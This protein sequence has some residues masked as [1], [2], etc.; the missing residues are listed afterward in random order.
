MT[1][2]Q[3]IVDDI[4]SF[5][6]A[7]DQSHTDS[8]RRISTEYEAACQEANQRLRRCEEYLQKGLRSE[9]IHLAE[10][11]PVL[12]DVVAALDF[13]ERQQWEEVALTYGLP[14]PPR[15]RTETASA[16]NQAYADEQPLEQL[17]RRHRRLAL[18]RAPLEERL[19]LMRQISAIDATNPVWADDIAVF[20]RSRLKKMRRDVEQAVKHHDWDGLFGIHD[21]LHKYEWSVAPDPDLVTFVRK[22][23]EHR[24]HI[25]LRRSLQQ[26]ASQLKSAFA[27]A[28][29][30]Q[31][32]MALK[33]WDQLNSEARLDR[34]DPIFRRA[35]GALQWLEQLNRKQETEF[36]YQAAL[37]R[38]E[39]ALAA[40]APQEELAD[41]FYNVRKYK[42][43]LPLDLEQRYS[44]KLQS[45]R[46]AA[47]RKERHVIV[48]T[49]LFGI[50]ALVSLLVFALARHI[51]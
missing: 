30:A 33:E 17:L 25:R 18:E 46:N 26:I 39:D 20:E 41:A 1:D 38:L 3:R 42:R 23:V 11:D 12:L 4:R 40:G 49:V 15:L 31:A 19:L 32:R 35:A 13:P 2:Y 50:V 45:I 48:G 43:N 27:T 28:D 9:A 8:L 24:K 21:E 44:E 5:L 34:Q 29:E 47:S 6:Q 36:A 7:S 14:P 37:E 16:L 10:A 22:E 51:H